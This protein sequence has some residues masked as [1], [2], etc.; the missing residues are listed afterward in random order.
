MTK[1]KTIQ[2]VI[3]WLC[4]VQE[5]VE[6]IFM[7][8]KQ[9]LLPIWRHKNFNSR[10]FNFSSRSFNFSCMF[11]LSQKRTLINIIMFLNNLS[12][13]M[14]CENSLLLGFLISH[15]NLLLFKLTFIVC[16]KAWKVHMKITKSVLHINGVFNIESWNK[17]SRIS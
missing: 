4:D 1:V 12:F 8:M 16:L 10:S 7:K 14:I 13:K 15:L 2:F 6:M 3:I 11:V 9:F 5:K 17:Q